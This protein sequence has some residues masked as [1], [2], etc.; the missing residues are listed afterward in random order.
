MSNPTWFVISGKEQHKEVIL[1]VENTASYIS[2]FNE[3]LPSSGDLI[4]EGDDH[5]RLVKSVLKNTFTKFDNSL[6]F[7]A[8]KLNKLDEGLTFNNNILNIGHSLNL[9]TSLTVDLGKNVFKNV[10]D[11][12]DSQDA[13]TLNFLRGSTSWPV[14]AVYLSVDNR[15][16]SE[17]FGFGSWER[18]SEGRVLLGAGVGF[19]T[20]NESRSFGVNEV[21]GSYNHSLLEG[22]LPSHNHSIEGLSLSEGGTHTHNYHQYRGLN[23]QIYNPDRSSA[24][25]CR[26][27]IGTYNSAISFTGSHTHTLEGAQADSVG[28]S[29]PHNNVQPYM[30]CN[31]WKRTA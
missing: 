1:S 29:R 8:N 15:N 28:G 30:V 4:K 25:F 23:V 24:N 31:I 3:N 27:F 16:P 2:D 13:V 10:S 22:E 20:N 19:D 9:N 21:G 12:T 6:S 18:I 7:S 14:G 5:L 17:I 26:D 11:P